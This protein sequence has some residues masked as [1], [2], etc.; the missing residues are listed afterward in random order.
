MLQQSSLLD[1]KVAFVCALLLSY[2]HK[3][4]ATKIFSWNEHP[5]CLLSAHIHLHFCLWFQPAKLQRNFIISV[6]KDEFRRIISC[7]KSLRV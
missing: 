3:D 5:Y 4:K 1:F 2:H 6:R 7:R